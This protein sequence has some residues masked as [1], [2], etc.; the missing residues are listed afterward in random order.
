MMTPLEIADYLEK[1]STET[2]DDVYAMAAKTLR[3]Q[4]DELE[5]MK[6]QFDRAIDFLAKC[7]GWSKDK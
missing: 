6:D 3:K 5:H 7:N 2:V 4:A 1:L